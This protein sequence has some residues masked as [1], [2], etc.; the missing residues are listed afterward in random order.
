M[1]KEIDLEE[2]EAA[3]EMSQGD[4]NQMIDNEVWNEIVAAAQEYARIKPK[5]DRMREAREE[6]TDGAWFF[7]STGITVAA[8]NG[9]NYGITFRDNS[10]GIFAVICANE[11]REE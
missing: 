5:W 1:T 2:L 6:A 4:D 7:D 10:N 11:L 9:G 3:L 8:P